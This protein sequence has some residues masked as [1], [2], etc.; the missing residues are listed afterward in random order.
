[1]LF[2]KVY[3][4]SV[5]LQS[6][7]GGYST[8]EAIFP[9]SFGKLLAIKRQRLVEFAD[10]NKTIDFLYFVFQIWL[11]IVIVNTIGYYKYNFRVVFPGDVMDEILLYI[12]CRSRPNIVINLMGLF[13]VRVV[14]LPVI[15]IIFNYVL[16]GN[17][18]ADLVGILTGNF[19]NSFKGFKKDVVW[20]YLMI[21]VLGHFWWYM[22]EYLMQVV[23]YDLDRER[24][25]LRGKTMDQY[26]VNRVNFIREA[27]VVLVLPPWYWVVA[28]R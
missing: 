6:Y 12:D 7:E 18:F 20:M 10:T 8:K 3:M 13:D 27:L 17:V 15:N 4:V 28:G 9:K 19:E 2:L 23:Y 16:S 22:R 24:S 14:Y 11:S 1:M 5:S 25:N 21:Y 26:G